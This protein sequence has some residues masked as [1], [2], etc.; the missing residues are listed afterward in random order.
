MS[1]AELSERTGIAASH[2]SHIERARANPTLATLDRLAA[3]FRCTVPDLLTCER[4]L[5]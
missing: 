5:R 1:Q 2:L 4:S 3:E